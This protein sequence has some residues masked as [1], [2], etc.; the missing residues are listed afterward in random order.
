MKTAIEY[1]KEV[2]SQSKTDI[3]SERFG[4]G[5]KDYDLAEDR[6]TGSPVNAYMNGFEDG[7]KEAFRWREMEKEP[8]TPADHRKIWVWDG[9]HVRPETR[10]IDSQGA[11]DIVE[12][13]WKYWRP[14]N[15]E[16]L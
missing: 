10:R 4:E 13:V 15:R 3:V 11:V 8:P 6:A 16:D 7:L 1:F 2:D 5:W 9:K 12:A 14:F